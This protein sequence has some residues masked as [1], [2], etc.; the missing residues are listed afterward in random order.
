MN[1]SV[2]EI[3]ASCICAVCEDNIRGVLMCSLR[4]VEHVSESGHDILNSKTVFKGI[5]DAVLYV[6]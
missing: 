5:I 3:P 4:F 6:S 2:S 1:L